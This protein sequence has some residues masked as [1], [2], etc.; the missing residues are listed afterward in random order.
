MDSSGRG[1]IDWA[2]ATRTLAGQTESGDRHWVRVCPAQ[3]I[4]AVVDGV[5]HGKEA[6]RAA[7]KA[8]ATLELS[9]GKSPVTLF[10]SC[11]E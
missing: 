11:D 9:V 10:Q 8:V 4:A 6:A 5:G 1:L 2:V 7:R 3:A